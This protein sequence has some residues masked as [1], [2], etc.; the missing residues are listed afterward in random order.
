MGTEIECL[1]IA[2]TMR[3]AGYKVEVEMRSRKMKKSLEYANDERIPFVFILGEDEL[4]NNCITVK[5]MQEKTQV[6]IS[7]IN[8]IEEFNKIVDK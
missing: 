6:Q 4:T 1:Q 3:K 2:E 8:I 7:T 5:N